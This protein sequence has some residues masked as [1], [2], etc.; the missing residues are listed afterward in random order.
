MTEVF[1]VTVQIKAPSRD[2]PGQV[3]HGCYTLTDGVVTLTDRDGHPVQDAHGRQYT[4]KLGPG[5]TVAD[6]DIAARSLTKEF[7]LALLSKTLSGND[8]AGRS[9]IPRGA[10]YEH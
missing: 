2:H 1:S 8:L 3:C 10:G 6:A 9:T 4:R 7:R 5:S